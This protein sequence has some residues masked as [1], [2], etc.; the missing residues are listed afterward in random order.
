MEFHFQ[1]D[2]IFLNFQVYL[3][4]QDVFVGFTTVPGFVSFTSSKGSPYLKV[5]VAYPM[6]FVVWSVH[7]C[8]LCFEFIFMLAIFSGP[9]YWT[10]RASW[11]K[12]PVWRSSAGQEKAGRNENWRNRDAGDAGICQ[13]AEE[14]SSLLSKLLFGWYLGRRTANIMDGA[15]SALS[16]RSLSPLPVQINVLLTNQ[17]KPRPGAQ[18]VLFFLHLTN[19]Q[20]LMFQQ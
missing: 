8:L 15:K 6:L 17:E 18:W 5:S 20:S 9:W 3:R 4:K 12:R 19:H 2:F 14:R 11:H 1:G 10:Y 7:W 13:G 16:S